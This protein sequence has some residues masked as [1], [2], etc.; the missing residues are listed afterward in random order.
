MSEAK[1]KQVTRAELERIIAERCP[2][3]SAATRAAALQGAVLELSTGE[4]FQAPQQEDA[5]A[6][7]ITRARVEK[8]GDRWNH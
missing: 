3:M 7:H 2:T 5:T 6:T 8:V 4:S 1:P